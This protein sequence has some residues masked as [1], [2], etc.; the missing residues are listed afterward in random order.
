L[1]GTVD[2]VDN[3]VMF[4]SSGFVVSHT[5]QKDRTPDTGSA[6]ALAPVA[7]KRLAAIRR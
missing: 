6:V 5:S 3:F 7:A 4:E 2:V 1:D